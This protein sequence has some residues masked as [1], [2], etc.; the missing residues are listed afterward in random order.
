MSGQK[1][2]E[3]LSYLTDII[4]SYDGHEQ[5]IKLRQYPRH[6]YSYDYSAMTKY[7]AQWLRAMLRIPQ[8]ET[9][10]IPMWHNILY[11]QEEAY[12]DS[13]VLYIDPDYMYNLKDCTIIEVF[14]HDD[15]PSTNA[16]FYTP[17]KRYGGGFIGLVRRLPRNLMPGASWIIP[18][19]P[20]RLQSPYELNYIY[21]NGTETTINFE[22][23]LYHPQM[24]IPMEFE[25]NYSSTEY[26]NKYNL[27]TTYNGREV[28]TFLPDFVN[29]DDAKMSVNKN[30]VRVDN[31]T[32]LFTYDMKNTKSYDTHTFTIT[33]G[34][35]RLINNMH[36]FFNKVCGRF[37]SFYTP[38]WVN[39]IEA[40]FDIEKDK[41]VIYTR[42][43]LA[44]YY[45]YNTRHR[46]IVVFTKDYKSHIFK[47]GEMESV[48]LDDK[49]DYT[50]I[51]IT[52]EI[53]ETIPI[54]KIFMISYLQLVRLDSDDIE[55]D[56]ETNVVAKTELSF[57]EVDDDEPNLNTGTT[58]SS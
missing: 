26:F 28:F 13:T 47:I 56:Y 24:N 42:V 35:K 3:K 18:L 11:V 5:R 27:P 23:V 54:N 34:D 38:T 39:D 32:G 53:K 19:K 36:I 1:I 7:E 4:T 58:V 8:Q 57:K 25:M 21:S 55:F 15:M 33:M 44:Q 52:S 46:L 37:K 50:K 12:K 31:T 49:L 48:T 30:I 20:C 22:E 14:A 10:Y 29:D 6:Y 16:N 41:K 45:K 40:S 43:Q 17:V 51:Y 2:T 9:Y